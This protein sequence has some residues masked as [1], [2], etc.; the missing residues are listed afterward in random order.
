MTKSAFYFVF[1]QRSV[2]YF[3][4]MTILGGG[5]L[6]VS[7]LFMMILGSYSGFHS[8]KGRRFG[9]RVIV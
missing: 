2:F 9:F 8:F 5:G 1:F 4:N 7:I 6:S 3:V